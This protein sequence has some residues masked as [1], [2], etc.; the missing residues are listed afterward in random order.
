MTAV[1]HSMDS[2]PARMFFH[3]TAANSMKPGFPPSIG[4]HRAHVGEADF[5][6]FPIPK[7][8]SPSIS[9]SRLERVHAPGCVCDGHKIFI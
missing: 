2:T 8:T 6:L 9:T 4:S 3:R 5:S 1:C 7:E